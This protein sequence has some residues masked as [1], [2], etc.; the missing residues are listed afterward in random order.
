MRAKPFLILLFMSSQFILII[1]C[2]AQTGAAINTTG[3]LPDNSS[4]LDVSSSTQGML[5]PRMA[6]VQTTNQSPVT[7][8]ATS[9]LVYNTASVND[10]TP[11]YYYWDGSKWVRLLGSPNDAWLT[12]GNSGTLSGTN[13]LGTTNNQALDIRTN[14]ILHTRITTKGQI[15][16]YNTG[17]SIFIG[18][19]AGAN[20]DLNNRNNVFIGY[21]SGNANTTG[22]NNT[23]IGTN[24]LINSTITFDNVAVGNSALYSNTIGL[25]NVAVGSSA[26]YSNT[27]GT[28]NVAVGTQALYNNTTGHFNTA[29]G[30]SALSSQSFSN[31]GSTWDACNVAVG[32]QS[33]A[34]NNPTAT[35]N[36][37]NNTAMG[38]ES[39]Y[40]NT[41]GYD[42]TALGY[43]VMYSNITGNYNTA[44][45]SSSMYSNTSG[46][47]NVAIGYNALYS[48]TMGLYNVATGYE[49]LRSN[50][51][52]LF[53][54]ANGYQALTANTTGHFNTAIGAW[55][56]SGQS[57]SNGGAN[58]DAANV[59]VGHQA[60]GSNN[61]TAIT[62]GINNTAV[63]FQT[64]MDNVTGYNNTALGYRSYWFAG[65]P[66]SYNNSMALGA[67]A[68]AIS[69]SNMVRVGDGSITSIGGQVG[70][71]TLS[72]KRVK[73]NIKEDIPGLAFIK[74]LKPVSYNYD[75][76]K[77]NEILGR[78][79]T[80]EYSEK[81][82]VEKIRFSGFIAQEVDS[83]AKKVGY[84][85]SGVDKSGNLW[86]LRYAEFVVPLVKAVKEQQEQIEEQKNIIDNLKLE[87]EQQKA[88][89]ELKY[90]ELKKEIEKYYKL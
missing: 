50:T 35:T 74:E 2:D 42:N 12:L 44:I 3:A 60:L 71:T 1:N 65:T 52:A 19:G 63:G 33:L 80:A 67:N 89:S 36:G 25:S 53:N 7:S 57:F 84:D 54:V 16:I 8:P 55:A 68:L 17:K 34:A 26:L 30:A 11:G 6:L 82:D 5:I 87:L 21:K 4:I 10:V 41:T 24:S 62:N 81:Y 14:N 76:Q 20:D 90:N 83:V 79:D 18:E 39:L 69:A 49:A 22:Y 40:K 85:F 86:G 13:F 9:L 61:P 38:F 66:T 56:L 59:A 32:H 72:D 31:G 28:L 70:W 58:W 47:Y 73:K 45:G 37:I 43:K 27:I 78:V 48:N 77:E 29:I 88:D 64:L 23:A 51:T 75:I 46:F 15:E